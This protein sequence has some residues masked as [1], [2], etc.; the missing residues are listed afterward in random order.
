MQT[1][2][3]FGRTR[4]QRQR[5]ARWIVAIGL[6][7]E[8]NGAV[9]RSPLLGRKVSVTATETLACNAISEVEGLDV[10]RLRG[11]IRPEVAA[12]TPNCAII[13]Q[14][15]LQEDL[16]AGNDVI[17]CEEYG[18]GG[19]DKLIR[20][21]RCVLVGLDP[22]QNEHDETCRHGAERRDLPPRRQ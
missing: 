16:L 5:S 6:Q 7:V 19:I 20:N 3:G 17:G 13:H 18:S 9:D 21:R 4:R 12:V 1:A 2:E 8:G 10:Q 11:K 15:V 22:Q 14:A